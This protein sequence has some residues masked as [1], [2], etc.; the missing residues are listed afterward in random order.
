MQ[1]QKARQ[2]GSGKEGK[3]EIITLLAFFDGVPAVIPRERF[4][5][6]K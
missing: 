1:M 4:F 2:E 3:E 5:A 6:K